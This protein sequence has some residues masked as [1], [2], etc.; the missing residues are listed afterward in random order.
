MLTYCYKK[1]HNT[2]NTHAQ[3]VEI[4]L[5]HNRGRMAGYIST[6]RATGFLCSGLLTFG[7]GSLG[8]TWGWRFVYIW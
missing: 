1:T 6:G 7:F 5:P 8:K 2:R 3:V 4:S